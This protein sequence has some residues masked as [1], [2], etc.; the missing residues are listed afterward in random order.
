MPCSR[1]IS[2]IGKRFNAGAEEPDLGV[3]AEDLGSGRLD[4]IDFVL[5]QSHGSA[6]E[7]LIK[8]AGK[9]LESCQCPSSR[10]KEAISACGRPVAWAMVAS[11]NLVVLIRL[12]AVSRRAFCSP[13]DMPS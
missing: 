6:L 1:A 10:R 8:G 2:W 11:S 3:F 5:I 13:K 4:D 7:D 12:Q 9:T